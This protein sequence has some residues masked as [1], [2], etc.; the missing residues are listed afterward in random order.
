MGQWVVTIVFNQMY[1]YIWGGFIRS[2]MMRKK[3]NNDDD[4]D[5]NNTGLV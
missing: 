5:D 3:L 4:D 2:M 1:M